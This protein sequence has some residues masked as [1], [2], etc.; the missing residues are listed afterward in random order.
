MTNAWTIG[1]F[2]IADIAIRQGTPCCVRIEPRD[3]RA[4]A[5]PPSD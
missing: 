4:W 1:Q 5:S 2:G 3:R